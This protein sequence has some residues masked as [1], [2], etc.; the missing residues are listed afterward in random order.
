M[1]A[2]P[3]GVGALVLQ[4]TLR[5]KKGPRRDDEGRRRDGDGDETAFACERVCTSDR[6][7]KRLGYLAKVRPGVPSSLAHGEIIF[8]FFRVEVSPR[9]TRA[10]QPPNATPEA[11]PRTHP[12]P[13]CLLVS[14]QDPTPNTCVTVCGTSGALL[15]QQ[16]RIVCIKKASSHIVQI[17]SGCLRVREYVPIC[18]MRFFLFFFLTS[19]SPSTS[20]FFSSRNRHRRLHGGLPA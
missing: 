4:R 13:S 11:D 6:L 14:S 7:I 2:A 18:K 16:P 20:L 8:F 15:L 10:S 12:T 19:T 17:F 5:R 9:N 1:I 3:V